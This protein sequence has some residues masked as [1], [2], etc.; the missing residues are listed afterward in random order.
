MKPTPSEAV[1][2]AEPPENDQARKA[3]DS[4]DEVE[5]G[6]LPAP[7]RRSADAQSI[8][9]FGL[10]LLG[11]FYTLHFARSF[12]LPIVVAL[13]LSLLL[14]PVVRLLQRLRLPR[15]LA[16]FLALGALLTSLTGVL[17]AVAEPAREWIAESPQ[18]LNRIERKLRRYR[19]PVEEIGRAA[20]QVGELTR[21]GETPGQAATVRE[22]STV[23]KF[24]AGGQ[25]FLGGAVVMSI[26]LFFLL[27]S[28]DLLLRKVLRIL[29]RLE[30]RKKAVWIARRIEQDI[31][32][33][34]FTVTVINL[35][36]GL[37][38]AG[39]LRVLG[40]PNPLLWGVMAAVLNFVP[41]LGATVGVAIL[42]GVSL[43]TFD[44]PTQAISAPLAYLVLTGLEGG[45]ITPVILGRRLSLNPVAIFLGLFFW[46]WIWGVAG[47]LLA[48]PILASLKIVCD[49]IEPLAGVGELLG[50]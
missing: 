44:A 9:V 47:A 13:L 36:L 8:A 15:S 33:H 11:L 1:P 31:S 32:R 17:Y 43:L 3:P 29:P 19:Q 7:V 10:F 34:L 40:M 6:P 26:L 28:D 27:A 30:D 4:P 42:A 37:A 35:C 49:R 41:Y 22:T 46:G 24:L 50:R 14:S 38:V 48:V 21:V 12:F 25:S 23:S 5:A 2:G 20:E 45:V 18:K 16:A 39:V